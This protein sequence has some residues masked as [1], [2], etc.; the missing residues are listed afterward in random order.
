MTTICRHI[1]TNG[2]RCG[3]PSLRDHA[4]CYFH[5]TLIQGHSRPAREATAILHPLHGGEPQVVTHPTLNLPPL[6]DREAIQ[7]ALSIIVGALARNALDTKRAGT[8]IY[9]LQVASAN[10]RQ[11]NHRPSRNYLV[12]ETTLTPTGHEIAPDEDPIGEIEYRQFLHD[13]Y[14]EDP[15]EAEDDDPNDDQDDPDQEPLRPDHPPLHHAHQPQ[16]ARPEQSQPG[17]LRSS[18]S[19]HLLD[20]DAEVRR[21]RTGAVEGDPIPGERAGIEGGSVLVVPAGKLRIDER[22][23]RGQNI[24]HI[25]VHERPERSSHIHPAGMEEQLRRSD[26]DSIDGLGHRSQ[27]GDELREAE[28]V[29]KRLDGGKIERPGLPSA[30]NGHDV[31][32]IGTSSHRNSGRNNQEQRSEPTTHSFDLG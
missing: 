19:T 30:A 2:E 17:E 14:N 26:G 18:R 13:L 9:G 8:L 31:D 27:P 12:T 10:A 29:I 21:D 5:R 15:D 7:L 6:E 3:S 4:F 23:G 16:H 28:R 11:L 22:P 24:E 25:D 1:K 32:A 20:A